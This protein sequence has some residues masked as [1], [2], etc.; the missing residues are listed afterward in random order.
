MRRAT[1]KGGSLAAAASV[2]ASLDNYAN[3]ATDVP[4]TMDDQ[5]I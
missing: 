2:A 4:R 3:T 1:I 5:R